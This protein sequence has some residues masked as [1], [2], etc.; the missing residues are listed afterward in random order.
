MPIFTHALLYIGYAL[1]S[2]T[3]GLALNQ[4]GGQDAAASFM[5]GLGLFSACAVTHA[6]LSAS[7][8][9]GRIGGAEKRI[10]GDMERLRSAHREVT[11]DIDAMQTRL[12]QLETAIAFGAPAAP[13]IEA[14]ANTELKLIDQIVDINPA[15]S[16]AGMNSCG[17]IKRPVASF[18]RVKPS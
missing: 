10:K 8:A 3:V 2:L 16:A 6:G 13:Q 7:F 11:A 14:G 17:R 9:A 5:G 4:I 18:R 15:C 12:D 1:I